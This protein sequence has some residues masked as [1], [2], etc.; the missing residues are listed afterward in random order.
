VTIHWDDSDIKSAYA[1]VFN[2]IGSHE[3]IVFLFGESRASDKSQRTVKLSNRIVLNPHISK[4]LL[5][6][7]ENA[8]R[9]HEDQYGPL[10]A[11]APS[12]P[13]LP[14]TPHPLADSLIGL[15]QE[16]NVTY[17]FE[18]SIKLSPKKMLGNRFLIT[19]DKND[20]ETNAHERILS[21]CRKLNMPEDFLEVFRQNFSQ[22]NP[23]DFGFEANEETCIY[24]AYLDFLPKWKR[25][26]EAGDKKP[27]TYLMFL[28]FKWDAFDNTKK[29][30]TKY[31]WYPSLS[32]EGIEERLSGIFQKAQKVGSFELVQEFLRV[33]SART[34]RENVYYLDVTEGNSRRR[35][36]DI[37]AYSANLDI[38]EM[39]PLLMKICDH[40]SISGQDFHGLYEQVK[41]K[42][43]GHLSGGVDRKGNDFLTIYFG[44]EPVP[45]FSA[46]QPSKP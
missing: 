3:E 11:E 44:L 20:I 6:L 7:L 12:P 1:N 24:K 29:A 27:E 25:E 19:I 5:I 36:F 39:Y 10:Q 35:S 43:F 41:E 2:V 9:K 37:N 8:L 14:V 4:R 17:D 18:R 26:G 34:T 15:V 40:Y 30:L 38:Q 32:Y 23:I 45:S 42:R 31:T 22:A 46:H 28:G 13:G 21:I 33:I 16:L